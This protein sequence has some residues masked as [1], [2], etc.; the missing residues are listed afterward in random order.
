MADFIL[1]APG[2]TNNP[3]LPSNVITSLGTSSAIRSDATGFRSAAAGDFSEFV[4]N[5]SYGSVI[6]VTATIIAGGTSNGDEVWIGPFVRS[7]ANIGAG[8]GAII[9]AFSAKIAFW[10]GVQPFGGSTSISSAGIVR[11]TNDVWAVTSS[12]VGGTATISVTQNGTPIVFGVNVNTN[13]TGE[14][15]LA[16]GAAF[17]AQNNNSMYLSQFTGTGVVSTAT[18]VPEAPM[19]GGGFNVQIAM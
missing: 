19:S 18:F 16:A 9:Q 1:P 3:W 4:H 15:S 6:T 12:V 7:G 5:A 8:F 10:T 13:F 2:T 17:N 14:A 11:G